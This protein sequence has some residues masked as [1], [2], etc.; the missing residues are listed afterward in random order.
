MLIIIRGEWA[1]SDG[2][3]FRAN[4]ITIPKRDANYGWK[5]KTAFADKSGALLILEILLPCE[6][7]FLCRLCNRRF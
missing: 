6:Y 5:M 7:Y 2:K 1:K 4:Y 3:S